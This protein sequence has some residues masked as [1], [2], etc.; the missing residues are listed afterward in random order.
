[1][2]TQS[3]AI[4]KFVALGP[5][6]TRLAA[7]L[8][9]LGQ[10]ILV[11]VLQEDSL[12]QTSLFHLTVPPMSGPPLHRHSREDEWFYVLE[13]EITVEVDGQRIVLN[14]NGSAFVK[15]GSVHAY[16]NFS[17]KPAK[18][19]VM[20]TPGGFERFFAEVSASNEGRSEP[21]FARLEQLMNEY[22]MELLGPPLS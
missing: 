4:Q 17:T 10:T 18:T 3:K 21:D 6:E 2:S 14:P 5:G 7:P 9:V 13:G 8:H 20:T 16:Q 1:M 11:K 22:G 15:R 19:L 12:G